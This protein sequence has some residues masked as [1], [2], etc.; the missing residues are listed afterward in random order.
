MLY[1]LHPNSKN[2]FC[3]DFSKMAE[4]K[5]MFCYR[6]LRVTKAEISMWDLRVEISNISY[7]F[8]MKFQLNS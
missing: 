2:I 1:T 4:E 5:W 8:M 3:K 6:D 7:G